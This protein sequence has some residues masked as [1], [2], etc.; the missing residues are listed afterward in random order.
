MYPNKVTKEMR[1]SKC[2]T[3]K[4][5]EESDDIH[6][7]KLHHQFGEKLF[8]MFNRFFQEHFSGVFVIDCRFFVT[9]GNHEIRS[10]MKRFMDWWGSFVIQYMKKKI[11]SPKKRKQSMHHRNLKKIEVHKK[12][13]QTTSKKCKIYNSSFLKNKRNFW[14]CSQRRTVRIRTLN[15]VKIQKL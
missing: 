1:F 9:K 14:N 4:T 6:N 5:S 8:E 7:R 12:T 11:Y 15:F 13:A 10:L 2:C 3:L